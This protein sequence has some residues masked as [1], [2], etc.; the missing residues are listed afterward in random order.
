M[1]SRLADLLLDHASRI[2]VLAESD[3]LGM[4]QSID[5]RFILHLFMA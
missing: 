1:H 5:L 2:P 4:P 3:K